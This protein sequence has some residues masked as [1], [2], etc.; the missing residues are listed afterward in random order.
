METPRPDLKPLLTVLNHAVGDCRA[1]ESEL[2]YIKELL[3]DMGAR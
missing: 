1:L 2:M 3:Y